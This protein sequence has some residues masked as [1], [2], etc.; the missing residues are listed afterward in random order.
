VTAALQ[1]KLCSEHQKAIEQ[2][3]DQGTLDVKASEMGIVGLKYR[4]RGWT[5]A[6]QDRAG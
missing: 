5:A 4:Q 6:T 1:N 2:D 3:G